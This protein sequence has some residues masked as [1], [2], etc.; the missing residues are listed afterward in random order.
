MRLRSYL[1]KTG[2]RQVDF[3]RRTGISKTYLNDLVQGRSHNPTATVV[4]L[5]E[6]ATQGAVRAADLIKREGA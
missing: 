5:I 4:A 2:E 1:R 3:A 6:R